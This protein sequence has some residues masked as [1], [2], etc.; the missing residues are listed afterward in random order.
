MPCEFGVEKFS[1]SVHVQK[2][3]SDVEMLVHV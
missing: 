2:F 1:Y 3:V